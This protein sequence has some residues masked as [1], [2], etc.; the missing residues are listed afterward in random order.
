[1]ISTSE[2]E[3]IKKSREA[4]PL[5]QTDKQSRANLKDMFRRMESSTKTTLD[6]PEGEG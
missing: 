3:M 5:G 1:M 2:A 6:D 4:A